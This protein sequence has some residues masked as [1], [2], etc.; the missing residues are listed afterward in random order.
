[1]GGYVVD[2]F[3]PE[4]KLIIEVDGG[5]HVDSASDQERTRWLEAQGYRVIRF[6]NKDVLANTEGV[7]LRILE[8]LRA[9]PPP[10]PPPQGG[11]GVVNVRR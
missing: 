3:C 4:A 2:F 9:G 8:A 6:W 5:Q 1:M 10:C 11:R 7:L